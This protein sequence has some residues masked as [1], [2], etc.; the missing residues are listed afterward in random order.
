[1]PDVTICIPTF[2]RPQSL[3]RLLAAI[4][5]LETKADIAVLVVDND[6]EGRAGFELASSLAPS[7]RFPLKAV[8]APQRGI[9]QVRNTLIAEAL[10][11]Q[12][13]FLA[14]IDDDEWPEARW[15]DTF[16]EAAAQTG[17][18]VLQGSILFNHPAQADIV[19]ASGVT[20]ML[21][22]AGNLLIRREVLEAMAPPWFDPEFALSGGEDREFFVR[23]AR[24]GVRFAWADDARCFGEVP[25]TRATLGWRLARAYSIGNSD[26][27]VLLKHRPGLAPRLTELS[28]IAAALLLGLPAALLLAPTP[29]RMRPLEKLFRALGKLAA[30]CGARHQ[31]YAVIHGQ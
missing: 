31:E 10:K 3:K 27:R 8:V 19:R 21:Q 13:R 2:R 4:A 15:I 29:R 16:L 5:A 11:D 1:M 20:D 24:A 26:M 12:T 14:M 18:G 9:A 30:M 23:L 7:F 25:E 28:K 22:G 6:A 17:A